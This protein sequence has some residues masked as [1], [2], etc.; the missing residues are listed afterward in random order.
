MQQKLEVWF[1]AVPQTLETK[2]TGRARAGSSR[3]PIWIGGG[4]TF[5]PQPRS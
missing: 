5:G 1:V 3:S 4:T 2:G